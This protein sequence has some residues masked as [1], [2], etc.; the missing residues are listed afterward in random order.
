[1]S[2]TTF[3]PGFPRM[4]PNREYKWAVEKFWKGDLSEEDLLSLVDTQIVNGWSTQKASLINK[5]LIGDF[6][7]YDQVLDTVAY[8]GI[9]LN[10][11]GRISFNNLNSYFTAARG[12]DINGKKEQPLEMTKWFNT[13]YHYLV[14]EID[15]KQSFKPDV[16]RLIYEYELACKNN[17]NVIPKIIGP[18]TLMALSKE[19]ELNSKQK[20]KIINVYLELFND[21]KKLGI[22]EIMLD[23]GGLAVGDHF[24]SQ[25]HFDCLIE[26][27]QA[28][29]LDIRINGYFGSYDGFLENLL[30][31]S[32]KTIHLDLCE[33]NFDIEKIIQISER[34]NVYLGVINGRSIWRNDLKETLTLLEEVRKITNSF[35]IGTSCSLMHVPY[36]LENE[37]GL[38]K[39]LISIL[40]FGKEKIEEIRLLKESL[41]EGEPTAELETFTASVIK[42][43]NELEGRV[44]REVRER[45]SQLK[46]DMFQRDLAREERL[47]LQKENI[48]IPKIPTTTIG[49]FPQTLETRSLR[50]AFKSGEVDKEEY[51]LGIKEIIKETVQIQEDIG[52]DIL[53]HGE[54]ERNDMVEYFGELL[55]GFAFTRNGWVQSYGSR[56]VKPPIIYGDVFRERKMTVDW[57]VYAQSLTK[58]PM[59]GMLTGPVTILKW[60]FVRDDISNEEVAYQIALSLRDEVLELESNGIKIIQIDE[61]AIREG[62]PLNPEDKD[63][64]LSWAVKSFKLSSSGVSSKTQI[65]SHMCYSEFDEILDAINALDVDVL[66]IEASRS[67]MDLVNSNLSKKYNGEIGPGVYDIHSPLVLEYKDAK[68]RIDQLSSN[69]GE[70]Y[71]WI[72]PDCG[73]KTRGWDEVIE[74]LTNMVQATIEARDEVS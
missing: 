4:G 1:M 37:D 60:S 7:F 56:C 38:D 30:D 17:Y 40:S 33:G 8:L 26:V 47:N 51:S 29:D 32:I 13:N 18:A 61:P 3:V 16:S 21:I 73:L 42:A 5:Q 41:E 52:L 63:E 25:P 24:V 43:N 67:G 68:E 59:K 44:V 35:E 55:N 58:K 57:S 49:S 66:S 48:G 9:P 15:W 64:Y 6:S 53:V 2:I 19:I 71:I 74:S 27:V 23:E 46:D 69:L 45:I 12:G 36:S 11:F 31:S 20:S 14:P 70:D 65:H 34:K 62:L 10:R 54:A 22:S 72:N 28:S 39:N 50:R